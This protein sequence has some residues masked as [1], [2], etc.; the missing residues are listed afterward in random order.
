M[1]DLL[2]RLLDEII[3]LRAEVGELRARFAPVR[4]AAPRQNDVELVAAIDAALGEKE[5]DTRELFVKAHWHGKWYGLM[6]LQLERVASIDDP[7]AA[8]RVG[9]AL[10][11]ASRATDLDGRR[12]ERVRS[13]RGTARWRIVAT[14]CEGCEG[15]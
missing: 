4:A 10:S 15:S 5:F 12:I 2:V 14:D 3:A 7:A 1:S 9:Q 13:Q 6:R 11:R 8:K